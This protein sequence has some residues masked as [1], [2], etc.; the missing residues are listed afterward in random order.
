MNRNTH[1]YLTDESA[2]FILINFVV[3]KLH[4]VTSGQYSLSLNSPKVLDASSVELSQITFECVPSSLH[5]KEY[6]YMVAIIYKQVLFPFILSQ[7]LTMGDLKIGLAAFNFWEVSVFVELDYHVVRL[8][9]VEKS[10]A[11]C[12]VVDYIT[13][14]S[15]ICK[16]VNI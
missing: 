12:R 15:F 1:I 13:E 11:F 6:I 9:C 4:V 16:K 3:I 8:C 10:E 7:Y 2:A 14:F 5:I